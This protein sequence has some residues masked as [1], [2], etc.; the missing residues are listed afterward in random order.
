MLKIIPFLLL[1]SLFMTSCDEAEKITYIDKFPKRKKDLRWKLGNSFMVK[2][3]KDTSNYSIK[4][5]D[6]SKTNY[7]ISESNDTIFKGSISKYRGLYYFDYQLNDTSFWIYTVEINTGIFDEVKTIRGMG[8]M[9]SQMLMLKEEIE[10]GNFSSLIQ[11]K[12]TNENNYR[13]EPDKKIMHEF[14]TAAIDSFKY[15]TLILKEDIISEKIE[16]D[17]NI[18][19]DESISVD[20]EDYLIY[21]NVF[22]NPFAESFTIKLNESSNYKYE[23]FDK[24]G[25][26][27][28][29]A[30]FKGYTKKVNAGN[31]SS[32]LYILK[33]TDLN[34]NNSEDLKLIKL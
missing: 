22:P 14:Y 5:D 12:D 23:L 3:G 6:A 31:L 26:L 24:S 30:V 27:M 29:S 10:K 20:F 9:Y 34:T 13:L 21:S 18:L 28:Q 32:G 33:I 1:F 8:E 17:L 11:Y 4:Y 25:K 19:I 15:D 16:N 2:N 7:I